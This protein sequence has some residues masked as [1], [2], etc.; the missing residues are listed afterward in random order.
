MMFADTFNLAL[1]SIR[2]SRVLGLF[3]PYVLLMGVAFC[4]LNGRAAPD[5]RNRITIFTASL[6]V[7]MY[8][9]TV[10]MFLIVDLDLKPRTVFTMYHWIP[11]P[12]LMT[13]VLTWIT[14]TTGAVCGHA[15]I[16]IVAGIRALPHNQRNL[17]ATVMIAIALLTACI[18]P[19]AQA[20]YW[21]Q[22]HNVER[23]TQAH[24]D[25]MTSQRRSDEITARWVE[26]YPDT[27]H[28]LLLRA[29]H[30]RDTERPDEA[31]R[32]IQRILNQPDSDLPPRT[33]GQLTGRHP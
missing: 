8:L 22:T 15:L 28:F 25:V 2:V 6:V 24:D 7:G 1:E 4:L 32:L 11:D 12:R 18:P 17:N 21:N 10:W 19:A 33:R 31:D 13:A 9:C 5:L 26:A 14:L 20:R 23:M 30:L 29:H 27:W 16:Y 3:V